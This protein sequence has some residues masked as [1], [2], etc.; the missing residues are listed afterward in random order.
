MNRVEELRR[1][2][3]EIERLREK[4]KDLSVPVA[5]NMSMI[6]NLYDVFCLSLKCQEPKADPSDSSSRKKFLYAVLYIFS[7]ATL[8]G[9]V[10]RHKLRECVS[11]IIGCTPTGISRDYKTGLFFYS[12]YKE[13]RESVDRIIADMLL[14]L[15]KAGEI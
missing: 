1:V 4:E 10:M 12:T 15:G 3:S 9:D 8:V 13:F 7:P 14:V 6:R 5:M 11:G 2:R